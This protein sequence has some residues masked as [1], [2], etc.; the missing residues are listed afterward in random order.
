MYQ[1]IKI[2][3]C[4][5]MEKNKIENY[6]CKLR[7]EFDGNLDWDCGKKRHDYGYVFY[8]YF[9]GGRFFF[10]SS[11]ISVLSDIDDMLNLGD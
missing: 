4:D 6:L 11:E 3:G 7:K 8:V 9:R 10:L 5:K 1:Q 2:K